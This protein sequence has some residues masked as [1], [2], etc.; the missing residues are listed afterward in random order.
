MTKN[1]PNV[2]AYSGKAYISMQNIYKTKYAQM[3]K[4]ETF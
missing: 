2:L 3:R 1:E 4:T